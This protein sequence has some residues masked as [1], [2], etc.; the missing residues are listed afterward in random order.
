A[1]HIVNL[2]HFIAQEV[3]EYMAELG[4]RSLDEMIGQTKYLKRSDRGNWK[5]QRLDL[6]PLL[7]QQLEGNLVKDKQDHELEKN[8]DSRELLPLY[9]QSFIKDEHINAVFPIR[10]IDRSVGT[11]LG[12]EVS[13]EFGEK[14]LAEDTIKLNFKEIGRASSRE[15]WYISRNAG[16]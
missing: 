1:D 4:F 15:R 7:H 5:S 10:N 9:Q 11:L 13:R 16:K 14:G 3:R 12:S 2:M 8:L 6:A